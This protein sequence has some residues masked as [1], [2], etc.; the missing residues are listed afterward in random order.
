MFAFPQLG[1]RRNS[2]VQVE[3]LDHWY[4]TLPF[5]ISYCV[6]AGEKHES[7]TVGF[8]TELHAKADNCSFSDVGCY[9]DLLTE[10]GATLLFWETCSFS[11]FLVKSCFFLF[12]VSFFIPCFSVP[13]GVWFVFI[14]FSSVKCWS[15]N[16]SIWV[17]Y[18][19]LYS[20]VS[21][22][23]SNCYS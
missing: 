11:P 18:V 19:L 4:C 23:S 9:I 21:Q 16:L 20:F 14:L 10:R 8:A 5:T 12:L 15:I 1:L 3:N 7:Q 2:Q 22:N 6:Y 13:Q 17:S